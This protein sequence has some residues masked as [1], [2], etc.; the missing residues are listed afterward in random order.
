[1]K[2]LLKISESCLGKCIVTFLILTLISSLFSICHISSLLL[3][4]F[5]YLTDLLFSVFGQI[6]FVRVPKKMGGH[7]RGFAFVEFLT[8]EQAKKAKNALA[9]T[10][11]YGR[12]LVL[13]YAKDDDSLEAIR[14]K[15]AKQF[16]ADTDE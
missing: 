5:S 3:G 14:A 1:M 6:K 7:H 4:F 10:H 15:T 12:H 16:G 8:S 2:A 9:N 11:L 13:E